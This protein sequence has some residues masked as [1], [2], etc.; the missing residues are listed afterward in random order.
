MVVSCKLKDI[1]RERL[2]LAIEARRQN[3]DEIL[4]TM[5]LSRQAQT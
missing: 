2:L 4:H 3:I 1:D 5:R